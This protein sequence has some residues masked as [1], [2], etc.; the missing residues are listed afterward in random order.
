M[1]KLRIVTKGCYWSIART[2]VAEEMCICLALKHLYKL[3]KTASLVLKDLCF[4]RCELQAM[5]S[6]L[7]SDGQPCQCVSMY[8][9]TKHPNVLHF[10]NFKA[11]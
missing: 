1:V 11:I 3:L 2:G 9:L 10:L 5:G 7:V 6:E 8:Q 4:I